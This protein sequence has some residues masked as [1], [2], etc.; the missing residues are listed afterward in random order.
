[1]RAQ[2]SFS[3]KILHSLLAAGMLFILAACTAQASETTG[4]STTPHPSA[5]PIPPKQPTNSPVPTETPIPT[6]SGESVTIYVIASND[7]PFTEVT[8][9][10]RVA[11]NDY[12][13]YHNAHGGISGAEIKLQFADVDASGGGAAG[14]FE[15]FADHED[16]LA[17]LM[18]APVNQALYQAI[19]A[20]QIPVIYFGVGALPLEFTQGEDYLF[21][22]VPPPEQQLA[23]W[24]DYALKNWSDLGPEGQ[25]DVMRLNYINWNGT[26]ANFKSLPGISEYFQAHNL[27]LARQGRLNPSANA[28]ASNAIL[29]GVYT[30][31]TMIYLDLCSY[32]P[33]IVLNDLHYLDLEGFFATAGGSWSLGIDLTQYMPDP[34]SVPGMY[35]PLP[36]AWWTEEENLGIQQAAA[37]FEFSGRE[38]NEKQLSYLYGLAAIDM[39][40]SAIQQTITGGRNVRNVH[41]GPEDVYQALSEMEEFEVLGGLMIVDF[42]NVN[43]SPS[44]MRIWRYDAG[45]GLTLISDWL[46]MVYLED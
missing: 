33:A 21:W 38:E 10:V 5:T 41:L 27:I 28:S 1:M 11:L 2:Y 46:P 32:G 40:A 26:Q 43:R 24:M 15:L 25:I 45:Q 14:A 29:D 39:A 20:R 42:S 4:S 12:A 36:I 8:T 44:E 22:L 19:N 30:Q 6:L 23:V 37:I 7:E 16:A 18:L 9:A 31:S 34:E 13:A 17:V 3:R 35:T